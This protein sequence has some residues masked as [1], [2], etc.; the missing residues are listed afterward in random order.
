MQTGISVSFSYG[1]SQALAQ[2][3]ARGAPADLLIAAGETPVRFLV[4]GRHV[5]PD[6][7]DLVSNHLVAVT[8]RGVIALES[9]DQLGRDEIKHLA[10]A[11]PA[12]APA[13]QYAKESLMRLGLWDD[14]QGK[15]V[16]G[17][18]VRGALTYVETGN[19]EVALV[20]FTDARMARGG[21]VLDIV[22]PESY[23]RITYPGAIVSRS[24]KKPEA[25]GFLEYLRSVEGK[26]IFEKYGFQPLEG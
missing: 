16:F 11:D 13:G 3:I 21:K 20:Y 12:L 24:E 25:V 9:M 2:Q 15:L 17:A 26:A 6:T 1:G 14:L 22:P 4:D 8:G 5:E 18:D 7:V 23:S 10:L 19:A